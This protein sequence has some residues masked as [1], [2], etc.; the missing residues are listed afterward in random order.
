[1]LHTIWC[2]SIRQTHAIPYSFHH[3][4][5][6]RCSRTFR[7]HKLALRGDFFSKLCHIFTCL[8]LYLYSFDF[9]R[10]ICLRIG[11]LRSLFW[12]FYIPLLP[13][14]VFTLDELTSYA[15]NFNLFTFLYLTFIFLTLD[16]LTFFALTFYTF[17]FTPFDLDLVDFYFVL[18]T[19]SW[20]SRR[21][22]F[23]HLSLQLLAF[24]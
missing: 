20:L 19:T 8:L 11:V 22:L 5:S 18:L 3:S 10:V 2:V 17:D 13:F 21:W 16:E 4:Y 6:I 9:W 1:M 23:T 14:I 7:F 15:V 24:I 12:P